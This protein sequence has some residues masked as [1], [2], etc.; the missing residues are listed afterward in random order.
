MRG[1][2]VEVWTKYILYRFM[3]GVPSL[4]WQ[5][6]IVLTFTTNMTCVIKATLVTTYKREEMEKSLKGSCDKLPRFLCLTRLHG[7]KI[8]IIIK[9]GVLWCLVNISN[10]SFVPA[11]NVAQS[12][13]IDWYRCTQCH[14]G[15]NTNLESMGVSHRL[16]LLGYLIF[17]C[18]VIGSLERRAGRENNALVTFEPVGF[19]EGWFTPWTMKSDHGRWRFPMV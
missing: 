8:F 2:S 1:G 11:T 14:A 4:F 13:L 18:C 6:H 5:T 7:A 19:V 10:L 15:A 12:I 16:L 3:K 9:W 17:V